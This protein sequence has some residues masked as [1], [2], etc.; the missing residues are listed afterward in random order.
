MI[1]EKGGKKVKKRVKKKKKNGRDGGGEDGSGERILSTW[2]VLE[3]DPLGSM[4]IKFYMFEDTQ[5]QIYIN[6]KCL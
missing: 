5:S 2:G 6:Q 1:K 4:C 3:G